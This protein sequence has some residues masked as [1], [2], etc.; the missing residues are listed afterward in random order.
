VIA[1]DAR[2]VNINKY[3]GII[4]NG[5]NAPSTLIEKTSPEFKQAMKNHE[6]ILAK[7]Q[8]NF[9]GLSEYPKSHLYY[10]FMAKCQYISGLTGSPLYGLLCLRN[11]DKK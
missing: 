6:V 4:S 8:G 2:E 10:L 5:D 1:E 7:G 11:N 9:E 3:A